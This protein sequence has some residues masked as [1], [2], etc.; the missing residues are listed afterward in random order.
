MLFLQQLNCLNFTSIYTNFNHH[1]FQIMSETFY[2][3]CLPSPAIAFG[4]KQG[5]ILFCESLKEGYMEAFFRLCEQFRTQDEPAFCGLSTLT[6][7]LNTLCV[8]PK[9]VWK[10]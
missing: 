4:S 7:V 3:R 10:G 9:R 2:R 1:T 8:D 6:M 5:K